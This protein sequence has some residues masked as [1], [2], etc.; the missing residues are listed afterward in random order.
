MAALE[1][2]FPSSRASGIHGAMRFLRLALFALLALVVAPA[3][4]QEKRDPVTILVSIDGF[5]A[6]YLQRGLTPTLSALA[7]QGISAAMRPSFP[8]KTYPNHYAI[9]TG[10]RPDR[11]GIVGNKMQDP[12]RPGETF[13]MKASQDPFWWREAEPIWAGAEKAGIRT[14]TMFWPGSNVAYEDVRPQDWFDYDEAITD[15]QRINAVLDWLRRPG[16][17]RPRFVTLYFDLVDTAGHHHGPDSPELNEAL[18]LVDADIARLRDGLAALGQ[19]ANLVIVA[20]HGMAATAP[21]RVVWMRDIANPA[22]YHVID[23]GPV[24]L[25]DAV[26]GREA[27]LAASLLR[28][29]PH[30]NCMRKADLPERLHYGRNPR[31]AP[32]VCLADMGW[33]LL[34]AVPKRFDLGSHGYDNRAPEMLALFIAAGPDIAPKGMLPTFD[35]VDI[36]ALLR[37]LLR[38]APKPGIDGTDAPFAGAVTSK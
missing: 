28:R 37:D 19:P 31:V 22:D 23:E 12:A 24:A 17:I 26:P 4:A 6:D 16:A 30:I 15:T 35:N 7:G 5:R 32:F 25:V 27:A 1:P 34:D 3:S 38:L 33:L 18:K 20:D 29:H 21:D 2:V 14:A 13:T 11:N 9:V 36:Y 8:T 10:L